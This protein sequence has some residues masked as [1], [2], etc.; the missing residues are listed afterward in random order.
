V[1][2]RFADLTTIVVGSSASARRIAALRQHVKVLVAPLQRATTQPQ[3]RIKLKWLLKK[4]GGEG[5][6]SLLVEGGGEVNAS[7]LLGGF[8]HR[9]AFFYAPKILGGRDARPA[10]GGSGMQS[11][12]NRIALEH[13]QWRRLG[14]DLLLTARVGK[15]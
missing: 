6:T 1:S 11:V 12:H 3:Q 4:L 13:A 7:F 10:V 15:R 8:G 5:V 2:D 9:V 14:P